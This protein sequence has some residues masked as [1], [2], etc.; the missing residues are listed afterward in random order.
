M[1]RAIR[2]VTPIQPTRRTFLRGAM[3]AAAGATLIGCD[4]RDSLPAGVTELNFYTFSGPEFR[5]LFQQQ[6]VPA[7]QRAHPNIRIRVNESMGDAGYDAKLLTLIAG[8]IAPDLFRVHQQNFPFYAAKDILL[9]LDDFLSRDRELGHG[10]F[11]P[12]LLDGTRYNGK[13][14]G[15]PT[16]FSP[17]VILYN[18]NLFDRDRVPY[19]APDWTTDDLLDTC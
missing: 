12:Q 2:D 11:Y 1:D 8:R 9:P 17:I 16:D 3:A 18:Q 7:F 19:P 4:R 14:L 15:L 6:L 13:L 5:R 10:D